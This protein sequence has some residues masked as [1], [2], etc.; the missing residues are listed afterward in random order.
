MKG[1]L[2]FFLAALL[3]IAQGAW[4]DEVT[5]YENATGGIEKVPVY[6]WNVNCYQKSEFV[7]PAAQLEAMDGG[8]IS[9]M[10]FYMQTKA[11]I[12]WAGTFQVFLKEVNSTTI[13][14]FSGT[15]GATTVYEG[16]LDARGST[17]TI[18]FNKGNYTYEGGNL[19]VGVYHTVT[20]DVYGSTSFY[21]ETVTGASVQGYSSSSLASVTASQQNAI[22]KTTFTY[23]PGSVAKPAT[24]EAT[25]VTSNSATLNWT[26][27]TGTYNVE[28]KKAAD[29]NW[30][31]ATTNL[32]A[33]TYALTGLDENTAYQARVQS[34]NGGDVSGWK[35]VSFTTLAN[36]AVPYELS[37]TGIYVNAATLNWTG[38]QNSYNVRYRS[39]SPAPDF[40]EGFE[41]E[42]E[43]AKWTVI[44]NNTANDV[45]SG[46][47][48]RIGDAKRSGAYGFRFSSS[49]SASDYNQY[50]ISP[51]VSG[52]QSI[53]FWYKSSHTT[54]IFRV[55][56]ST[57]GNDVDDFDNN[58]GNEIQSTSTSEWTKFEL[59]L[60]AGVKYVAINYYS[61][62][63][64][65]LYI[66]DITIKRASA[67][68]LVTKTNV[69]SPLDIDGLEPETK[70]EWQVQGIYNSEPTEW[71]T[72]ATF[73]TEPCL[74]PTNL[75][76]A[77]ITNT[78]A[79]ATWSG[80]AESYQ[81]MIGTEELVETTFGFEDNK[82]P[83]SFT[84][85]AS[86]PWTVVSSEHH[87]GSYC[88][89]PGNKGVNNSSSDLTYVVTGPCTVSF[90]A[91][92]SS[93]GNYDKGYF[94]IDGTEKLNISGEQD[95]TEY[96]YELAAGTH[97]LIW[98]YEKD[99]SG[100]VGYDLFYVDDITITA[101]GISSLTEYTATER[102]YTFSGLTPNTT[103][104]VK[105][106]GYYGS[107][108]YSDATQP[109]SFTTLTNDAVPYELS[110]TG[111]YANAATLNWTGAQNSYN[112]HYR[113][114]SPAPDFVEDF[115]DELSSSWQVISNTENSDRIGRHSNANRTGDYGFRFSSFS[116]ASDYNQYLISPDVSG[117]QSVVFYYKS[118]N[119]VVE[120]FRVGYSTTGNDV[121]N[122][123]WEDKIQSSSTTWTEFK[124]NLPAG[125]KYVAINYYSQD[126]Y[127][128]YIDDITIK[129]ASIGEW[130]EKAN[131]TSPLDI[132]GLE[133]GTK[134]EWQVQGIYNSVPTEWS[135]VATFTTTD[136][137]KPGTYKATF[138]SGNDNDDWSIS[139]TSGA[140]GTTVTVSYDG[141]GGHKVKSVRVTKILP[142]KFTINA[143]GDQ[144]RFS[145]GNLQAVCASADA[146]GSTQESWTWQFATN[147]WDCV[148]NAA[149]NNSV[150]GNGSVSTAGT[151]D[152]FGWVGESSTWT[153]AAQ[154]GISNS[155]TTQTVDGYGNV[156]NENLKSDWGNNIGSG[157][158]TLTNAEW[159]WI[160]G[161]NTDVTST[162][163][164]DCRVSGST[165][166]GTEDARYTLA[167]INTDGTGVNG[168]ILFPDGVDFASSEAT[169][170]TI[171]DK[172]EWSTKCTTAQ[173]TALETKGCVFLPAA[174]YRLGGTASNVGSLGRYSSSTP[175]SSES[176]RCVDF[177]SAHMASQFPRPR[178]D[179]Y[180]V[181][182]VK[183]AQ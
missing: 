104:Q 73:T 38:V 85:D 60:P 181:R 163:G 78:Q 114:L 119:G 179:G 5:A 126:L 74:V 37:T 11:T 176:I 121:D 149:A 83:S 47:L 28:Y 69:T 29:A 106:K 82:I 147:Q 141:T 14:D 115:E 173:W 68:K 105:V 98:R 23:T 150:N 40:V 151:V 172:S 6:G 180:S 33:Y 160:L 2:L 55:G 43:F 110:T 65:Y 109:V 51:D 146:D 77:N 32:A 133:Q 142:G 120:T 155:T 81:V 88:I 79:T 152:L 182:L 10:T 145:Q 153:G 183:D 75:A 158:R 143:S 44:S 136:E 50:L 122:F 24:L 138:A 35:I 72:M 4:A 62:D 27:G 97:T 16:P 21:G 48:G 61:N 46:R 9:Q 124:L 140:E 101:L 175:N 93:E 123:T 129:C 18:T 57:T 15:S 169:W 19:L 95:W 66:D 90:Y 134:Y 112:V 135:T 20:G 157:W 58:W 1:K 87:S 111:I 42:T 102:S 64:Y 53:E 63:K 168:M 54:E 8:T 159:V 174:G 31:S 154:Y 7:I 91:K 94:L 89:I 165:V 100:Q 178:S 167:T 171:N 70:Y 13:S 49:S 41:E 30:T 103:Y 59:N 25:S 118:P 113:F 56:Y 177:T 170:G 3:A 156:A 86:H 107:D 26:G 71:S 92:I 130:V 17:L 131:V 84:N 116:S 99:F 125:V 164:T 127:Y 22:P 128:L 137:L 52:A 161:R 139:P 148:G 34:V 96:S 144:V 162:P 36:D 67:G 76:V 166:N 108:D 12:E 39:F 132:D 45:S 117:A 80:T